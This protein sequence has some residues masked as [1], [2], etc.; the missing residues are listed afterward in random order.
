VTA[1]ETEEGRRW[2]ETK[3]KTLTGGDK[4][5]ARFM[6][7]DFFEYTPQFKLII[8]GNHKPTLRTVDEAI[9]RRFHLV[10]FNVT[11]PPAERDPDLTEKLRKEWPGI[12]QWIIGGCLTWQR[13]GLNPPSAVRGATAEYLEAEDAIAT[14]LIDCCVCEPDARE[15]STALFRSWSD[16]AKTAGEPIG[17]QRSFSQKMEARFNPHRSNAA[18]GFM[19]LK[20]KEIPEW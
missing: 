3:I 17:S 13:E 1:I 15:S 4:I 20:L 18:K 8:A 6:R 11:I 16:W 7:G 19:G 5:A 10:P 2:D 14:W 9:R 12:L